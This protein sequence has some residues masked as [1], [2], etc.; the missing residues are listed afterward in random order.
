MQNRDQ[1]QQYVWKLP[2]TN[3][4]RPMST[5]SNDELR[6]KAESIRDNI[7]PR[8]VFSGFIGA[9]RVILKDLLMY[10]AL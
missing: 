4:H 5:Y 9:F 2:K 3:R 1:P 8:Y 7:H 10:D 6:D